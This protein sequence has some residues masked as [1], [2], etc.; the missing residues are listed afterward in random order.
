[1]GPAPR[2]CLPMLARSPK[3]FLAAALLSGAAGCSSDDPGSDSE[4][5]AAAVPRDSLP[6]GLFR[7]FMD[8]KYDGLGHPL[9]AQVWQAEDECKP[10]TGAL[11][12]EGQGFL[13]GSHA[14]GKVCSG[15]SKTIGLGGFTLNVRALA[16][17]TCAGADCTTPVLTL[18][19]KRPDGTTLQEKTIPWAAFSTKLTY[20]NVPLRFSHAESGPVDFEVSWS[21]AVSARVDYV[22]L[23]RSTQNLLVT[24]S[25]VFSPGSQIEVEALDPPSGFELTASCN[26]VEMA[27]AVQAAT[28]EDT[29]FRSVFRFAADA[30]VEACPLPSRLGFALLDGNWKK[31]A[32]RIS[33]YAEE[34]PC[35][36]TPGTTRVL[37]TGFEPF[38]ATATHDNSSERGVS[39]FDPAGVPGISV[40]KLTLPVEFD[41]APGIVKSAIERCKPDVVI[42][43]GQGRSEV[44]LET[45][46]YNSKDSAELAGGFPDNRGHIPG[47]EPIEAGGP[48][49]LG[50]GLPKEEIHAALEQAGIGVGYSDD[51]GRFVCNNLFYRIMTE[52]AGQP[53]VSGF[54]HMP[55]IHTVDATE[56]AMLAK[57]VAAAVKAAVA[58]QKS[59]L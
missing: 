21:G 48:A 17:E 33:L 29:E 53:R 51:P 22:E 56:Q 32:A 36:F 3:L 54:V 35:T 4:P 15:S 28:R 34:P 26:G 50:T 31:A 30:L 24:P 16:Y 52:S 41:T 25:G 12:A 27:G 40:M 45:T 49:E 23:F 11:E 55:Y 59:L 8:G 7:D 13:A 47:G 44:D 42:G 57:V 18:R 43:F 58:K 2:Q 19:A 9:D 38:P 14:A 20:T 39:G 46:A 5:P 10:A 37:L 1:M 6:D